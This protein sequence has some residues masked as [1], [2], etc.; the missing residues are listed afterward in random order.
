MSAQ[1]QTISLY[2]HGITP[3]R[4]DGRYRFTDLTQ[5]AQFFLRNGTLQLR[6]AIDSVNCASEKLDLLVLCVHDQDPV[7]NA[8]LLSRWTY[9][10]SYE[11]EGN[12]YHIWWLLAPAAGKVL[13]KSAS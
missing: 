10:E 12:I 4:L 7:G 6:Y 11:L 3:V 1:Q 9:A 5:P 2:R 8:Q 13:T